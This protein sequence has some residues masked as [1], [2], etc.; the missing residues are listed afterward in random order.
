MV[1]FKRL[2]AQRA[3][4]ELEIKRLLGH[5]GVRTTLWLRSLSEDTVAAKVGTMT[6]FAAP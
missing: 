5:P 3:Y 2:E 1:R 4:T 6:P